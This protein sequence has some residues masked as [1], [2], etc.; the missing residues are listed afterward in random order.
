VFEWTSGRTR[1]GGANDPLAVIEAAVESLPGAAYACDTRGRVI[2][3]NHGA[4]VM[5]GRRSGGVWG[6]DGAATPAGVPLGPDANWA[7][8]CVGEGRAIDSFEAMIE[9]GDGTSVDVLASARPVWSATGEVLGVTCVLVDVTRR[10]LEV[11]AERAGQAERDAELDDLRRLHDLAALLAAQTTVQAVLDEALRFA[12]TAAGT[13]YGML[14]LARDDAAGLEVQSCT[15]FDP[16]FMRAMRT[17][18]PGTRVI[19]ECLRGRGS[20]AIEDDARTHVGD[21]PI[22]RAGIRATFCTPLSG[23]GGVVLGVLSTHFTEPHRATGRER[24]LVEGCARLVAAAVEA[25]RGGASA[26]EAAE[27]ERAALA[28]ELRNPLGP[29]RN[30]L[31]L[32]RLE[33]DDPD[34]A[35][36]VRPMMERQVGRLARVV[37]DLVDM[38]HRPG[39]SR[40]FR[41]PV[42]LE[43]AI[44]RALEELAPTLEQLGHHVTVHL[45]ARPVRLD[46]DPARLEQLVANLVENAARRTRT[47]AHLALTATRTGDE[48]VLSVQDGALGAPGDVLAGAFEMF[49]RTRPPGPGGGPRVPQGLLGVP[50]ESVSTHS[51]GAELG[52]EFVLRLPALP[53]E[54]APATTDAHAPRRRIL[55]VDDI[56]DSAQSLQLVLE[57]QGHEVDVAYDGETAL[58]RAREWRPDIVLLDIG[59]PSVSGLD[60]ARAIRAEPWG[61]HATLIAM[62]GLGQPDD[63]ANSRAAG[64]DEHLVKPIELAQLERLMRALPARGRPGP[65]ADAA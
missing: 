42:E 52:S 5:W 28:H 55:V 41:E 51:A 9:R 13:G 11:A 46:A 4:R 60:V 6:A 63:I 40:P 8:R 56:A 27:G 31:E 61:V 53:L 47:P 14:A 43:P 54:S 3:S 2:A 57:R 37:D 32:M 17:A 26:P 50:G 33:S 23:R 22:R 49:T 34:V 65:D 24:R 45:P 58:A 18:L 36:K 20:V 7:A 25:G 62:T 21:D 16:D 39:E 12:T 44:V 38:G 15:G 48:L 1:R 19:D 35:R 30:A 59:L 29:I 10:R 64:F